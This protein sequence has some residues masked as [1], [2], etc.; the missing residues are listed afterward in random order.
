M[1]SPPGQ[2]E[3]NTWVASRVVHAKNF[4]GGRKPGNKEKRGQQRKKMKRHKKKRTT[5]LKA[6][7]KGRVKKQPFR[8][9]GAG[10]PGKNF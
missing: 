5:T 8:D 1:V 9:G 2:A 4:P 10:K 6:Q 7:N 3:Q